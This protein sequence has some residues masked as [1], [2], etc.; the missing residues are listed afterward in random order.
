MNPNDNCKYDLQTS[1]VHTCVILLFNICTNFYFKLLSFLVNEPFY[2]FFYKLNLICTKS[3]FDNLAILYYAKQLILMICI[4][5][6][7]VELLK[8]S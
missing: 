4:T 3:V 6:S 5:L 1:R 2:L 8:S 7:T